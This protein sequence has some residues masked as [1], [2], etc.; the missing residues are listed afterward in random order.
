M[1]E[2]PEGRRQA[3]GWRR[4]L[5]SIWLQLAIA[6]LLSFVAVREAG[7]LLGSALGLGPA[8]PQGPE[9]GF[10]DVIAAL[11]PARFGVTAW[12][13]GEF[14]E[15]E[16][17]RFRSDSPGDASPRRVRVEVLPRLEAGGARGSPYGTPQAGMDWLRL[18]AFR[19][20]RARAIDVYRFASPQSLA[21][22]E[23]NPS[24]AF[25]EGYFPVSD[26][27]PSTESGPLEF[28]DVG[29]EVVATGQGDLA[30]RKL[31][32]RE[33]GTRSPVL[34]EVWASALVPP[35]GVARMRV[36]GETWWL[37]EK[38]LIDPE[39]PL[40]EIAPLLDGRATMS[41]GCNACHG[42]D[43]RER[44]ELGSLPT[45]R[46]DTLEDDARALDLTDDLYHRIKA[47]L[48]VPGREPLVLRAHRA[49]GARLGDPAPGEYLTF[50]REGGS[51]GVRAD[52]RGAVVVHMDRESALSHLVVTTQPGCDPVREFHERPRH[53]IR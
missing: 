2:R 46:T 16:A 27:R 5:E 13:P 31:E 18:R 51:F 17:S 28:V 1:G 7:P 38:G 40:D 20:F 15:Y 21:I 6:V 14:A 10:K 26:A 4:V 53:P 11:V 52:R 35:L 34:A 12:Q 25:I 37:A 24:F 47:G 33:H 36:A 23:G 44:F 29:L 22:G 50:Q 30:C 32:L 43:C 3:S 49:S 8:R 42:R 48:F 39:P 45:Q 41:R 19:S 9:V